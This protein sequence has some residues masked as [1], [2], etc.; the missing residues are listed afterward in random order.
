MSTLVT[1]NIKGK[2]WQT[3]KRTFLI[4][5]TLL[6]FLFAQS[7]VATTDLTL[8]WVNYPD[9][10]NSLHGLIQSAPKLALNTADYKP[11]YLAQF[12]Q[13]TRKLL[14]QR[15]SIIADS[16]INLIAVHFFTDVAYGNHPPNLQ[17]TGY[18]FKLNSYN[19]NELIFK[20]FKTNTLPNLV[21]YLNNYSKEVVKLL[22]TLNKYQ[23]SSKKN[24]ARIKQLIRATNDYRWLRAISETQRIVLV[25]IPSAQLKVYERENVLLSM[26]LILGKV[27]T[28]SKTFSTLIQKIT[29]NPY[30]VVPSS[31]AINEM[32]PKLKQD[33][34][35]INRNHL[36][37]LNTNYKVVNSD[38]INWDNYDA[39]NFPFTIR[40]STGCDNSL[41]I[42]KLEFD[43]PFGVYLH[44]TPEKSL[45]TTNNRFYSHGCMRMEKPIEMAKLLMQKNSI[46]LDTIDLEACSKR[47]DPITIPVPEK[48]PLVVWYNLIDFD[49]SGAVKFYKDVYHQFT[50]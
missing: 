10:I 29:I 42:I 23:D 3:K 31:I 45:F 41:G 38:N 47:P 21:Q 43:S 48:I 12:I 33:N 30:W 15:D 36:Q 50:Y 44:D 40:Q 34:G 28:P 27:S 13:G 9:R 39:N 4:V 35:Y 2:T 18:K 17:S 5:F 7:Q 11:A 19:V 26:K 25:N 8:K 16:N 46:A 1:N 49:A 6:S 22:V 20:H 24:N 37:V 32:L 14:N